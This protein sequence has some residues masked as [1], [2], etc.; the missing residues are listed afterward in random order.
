MKFFTDNTEYSHRGT[1]YGIPIYIQIDEHQIDG[2]IDTKLGQAS[3]VTPTLSGTNIIFD[4]LIDA[5]AYIHI[6]VVEPAK[7]F[8]NYIL[9]VEYVAGFPICIKEEI[10]HNEK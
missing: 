2:I 8:L 9:G 1:F 10:N 7:S 5:A 4:Y 3:D 6:Y